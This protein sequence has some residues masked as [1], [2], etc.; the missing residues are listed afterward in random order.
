MRHV[1]R[2]TSAGLMSAQRALQVG[3]IKSKQTFFKT[4]AENGGLL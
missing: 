1:Q 3:S 2:L 4:G